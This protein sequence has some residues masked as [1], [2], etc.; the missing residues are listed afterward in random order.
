M[1]RDPRIPDRP[2]K[3][4]KDI[5]LVEVKETGEPIVVLN[6]TFMELNTLMNEEFGI[7]GWEI[8]DRESTG[9]LTALAG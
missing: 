3:F 9:M 4:R 6:K 8:H 7:N 5:W 1:R 2:Q